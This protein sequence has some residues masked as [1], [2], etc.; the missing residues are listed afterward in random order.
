M[1][2]TSV[3]E[4][5]AR[6]GT[7]AH[8]NVTCV[9]AQAAAR[10]QPGREPASRTAG[11]NWPQGREVHVWNLDLRDMGA[12]AAS[13]LD[14]TET[15]RAQRFVYAHDWRRY[16]AAHAWLRRILGA[17]SNVPP[18]HLRFTTGAH[19]KPVLVQKLGGDGHLPLDFNLS[20][21]KD[22]ALVAVTAGLEVGVDIEAVRD[23]LPG[24]DL[25]AGVLS[26]AELDELAQ[27]AAPD[28]PRAFVGCWT[29]KEACL[30][31]LGVGLG[32]EPRALYVGLQP[33]R[34]TLRLDGSEA[35]I[36]IAPLP[37]PAGY[38]AALAVVGG[39]AKVEQ[40]DV[41]HGLE[42]LN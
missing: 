42:R 2:S 35:P 12:G 19:G 18:Q 27:C 31:A 17:Y 39:F 16:V 22:F 36:D 26:A 13:L 3:R 25:A 34:Q 21:S 23:D 9:A 32:L 1:L 38:C 4:P 24:P 8:G 6:R 10:A 28:H 37:A 41:A 20:H 7:R 29:R 15:Q 40:Q 30:K 33:R 14:S 11:L 5:Q